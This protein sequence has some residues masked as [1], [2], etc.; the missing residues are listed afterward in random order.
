MANTRISPDLRSQI[1][2]DVLAPLGTETSM[3]TF[4]SY[5]ELKNYLNQSS[6]SNLYYPVYGVTGTFNAMP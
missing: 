1:I 2:A 3:Q 4:T 6:S 5:D